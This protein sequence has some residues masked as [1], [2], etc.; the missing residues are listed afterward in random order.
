[1]KNSN[2]TITNQTHDLPTC[3]TVPQP[4]V[5]PRALK[6]RLS[7]FNYHRHSYRFAFRMHCCKPFIEHLVQMHQFRVF[8]CLS[9]EKD[10]HTFNRRDN[11]HNWSSYFFFII[12]Q[13]T[14]QC[15][16]KQYFS[17]P[18]SVSSCLIISSFWQIVKVICF[19]LPAV[20]CLLMRWN[21]G[22]YSPVNML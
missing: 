3:S 21:V 4:T 13:L 9:F 12:Q 22:N 11:D 14:S 10:I 2:D 7:L 16:R 18:L 19:L 5:L 1:M 6:E 15:C 8:L 20:P 17:W